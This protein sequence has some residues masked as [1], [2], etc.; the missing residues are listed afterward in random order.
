MRTPTEC[1]LRSRSTPASSRRRLALLPAFPPLLV[2]ADSIDGTGLGVVLDGS[3]VPNMA[4]VPGVGIRVKASNVTIAE[5]AIQSF[6]SDGIRIEPLATS[7]ATVTGVMIT[8]NSVQDNLDGLRVSGGVGPGNTVEATIQ[9]NNFSF[10]NDDGIIVIGSSGTLGDGGNNVQVT[11]TD[12]TMVGSRGSQT[13]GLRT[14]DG[15]RVLGG[16]GFGSDNILNVTIADNRIFNNADDGIVVAG[17]GVAGAS[18]NQISATIQDNN[19]ARNG[20]PTSLGG[21][22]ILVRAGNRGGGSGATGN[23]ISASITSNTCNDSNR[24]GIH[25]TGG[26][27]MTNSIS[28][29]NILNNV[30]RRN[31]RDGIN[32]IGGGGMANMLSGINIADNRSVANQTH[33]IRVTP[34]SG[35]GNI[36][37]LVGI[38]NNR[39]N[40]NVAGDGILVEALV[41][42]AG[43]TPISGNRADGN[44]EDGIDINSLSYELAGNRAS[45]NAGRGIDALGNVDGGGNQSRRNGDQTCDPA[46]CI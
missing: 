26:R 45:R 16:A 39:A 40:R 33:G 29:A 6:P 17:A 14:G 19:I 12:N 21:D 15:I 13:G 46:G 20:G 35:G 7:G 24:D 5:L 8:N 18:R 41:P 34:G 1:L 38:T 2:Q 36:V 27:G 32:V 44:G 11:I 28:A 10:N 30:A 9:S 25:V 23:T 4:G 43:S 31:G 3:S 37:S 42:G 22:G